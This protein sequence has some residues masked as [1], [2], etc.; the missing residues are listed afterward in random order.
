M[1]ERPGHLRQVD[2]VADHVRQTAGDVGRQPP[3]ETLLQTLGQRVSG[4]LAAGVP[5]AGDQMA[6]P[7]REAQ[8]EGAAG[9]QLAEHRV[10][11]VG[12]HLW[13]GEI[14]NVRLFVSVEEEAVRDVAIVRKRWSS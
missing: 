14:A 8:R 7:S 12:T 3:P 13:D 4:I 1:V 2:V 9:A 11:N 6:H 5:A 10:G